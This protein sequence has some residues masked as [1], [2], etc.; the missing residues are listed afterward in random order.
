M[1]VP[2][3]TS[4]QPSPLQTKKTFPVVNPATLER[5]AEVPVV[6]PDEVRIA[7]AKARDAFESWRDLPFQER[8]QIFLD[9][10][11]RVLDQ[12]KEIIDTIVAETGKTRTEALSAEILYVCAAIEYYAKN[13]EEFLR[14]RAH[15]INLVLLKTKRVRTSYVPRG[16]VGIIAPWNF[17]LLM[18]LGESIPALMAGNAVVVKPSE[19]TPLSAFLGQR[20]AEQS[21][22]P[23]NLLQVVTGFGETGE[24]LIDYAD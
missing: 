9:L 3:V 23:K 5:I 8:A 14:D 1:S 18:T 6:E 4:E 16:V 12:E 2:S 11:N 24:A 22:L 15:R 17:P 20:L 21:G 19:F 10:R 13:A 7:V